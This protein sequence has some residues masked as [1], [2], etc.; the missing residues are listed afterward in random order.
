MPID[1]SSALRLASLIRETTALGQALLD[2]DAEEARFR[3]E[4][5]VSYASK[6]GLTGVVHAAL[7]VMNCL[8]E[9]GHAVGEGCGQA[10]HNLSMAL[11]RAQTRQL[12]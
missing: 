5:V 9:A 2:T 4:R 11:E 6:D 1:E 10:F 8:G 3:A 7:Q 12:G